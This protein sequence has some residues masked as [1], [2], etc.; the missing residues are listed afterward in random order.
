MKEHRE[1]QGEY[2]RPVDSVC[3]PDPRSLSFGKVNRETGEQRSMTINDYYEDVSEF[4]L[5]EG[6]PKEVVFQFE[7]AKNLY[8]YAWF[9]YRFFQ[10]SEFQSLASLELALRTRYEKELGGDVGKYKRWGLKAWLEYSVKRGDIK[11]ERFPGRE[12]KAFARAT[13][14]YQ[15]ERIEEMREKG[16]DRI[17]MDYS[18]V[19]VTDEDRNWDY[20]SSI[21]EAL[22]DLRNYH[23]HG[24]PMLRGGPLGTIQLV[25]EIINQLYPIE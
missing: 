18:E 19:Q 5:N 21:M 6:V 1:F 14:R 4:N 8:L 23:A 9:V 20:L 12:E 3:E 25:P 22:P 7:N 16:L 17:D 13:F 11:N 2:L 24:T 10:A 15:C